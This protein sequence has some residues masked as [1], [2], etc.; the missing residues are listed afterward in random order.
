MRDRS[1]KYEIAHGCQAHTRFFVLLPAF[2]VVVYAF[3]CVQRL[4]HNCQKDQLSR[5]KLKIN[6]AQKRGGGGKAWGGC[7]PISPIEASFTWAGEYF[8]DVQ[9]E[10]GTYS[11]AQFIK[12]DLRFQVPKYIY[13]IENF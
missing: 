5:K 4:H 8:E 10:E 13:Y 7:N 6:T 3:K 1:K 2:E 11:G 9:K 12:H